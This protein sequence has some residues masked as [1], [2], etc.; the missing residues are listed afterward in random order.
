MKKF[1]HIAVVKSAPLLGCCLVF[2]A[3]AL[4][5]TG[6]ESG[7]DRPMGP[8]G[9]N[10]R[11]T[12]GQNYVRI[13]SL[14]TNT[15][16]YRAG[17]RV[18]DFIHGAFG[19]EFGVTPSGDSVWNGTGFQG[20]VQDFGLS[21]ERAEEGSGLLPLKVLRA[22][23]GDLT[24][25]V[26]LPGTNALGPAYP[27]NSVKYNEWYEIACSNLHRKLINGNGNIGYYTPYAGLALMGHPGALQTNGPTPYRLALD[28]IRDRVV[29]ALSNCVYAPVEGALLDGTP[30]PNAQGGMSNWELGPRTMFLAEYLALTADTNVLPTLQ[31]AAEVC[32]NCIQWWNVSAGQTTNSIWNAGHTGHGGVTGDYASG[33]LGMNITGLQMISGMALAARAGVDMNARPRDG[34]YFGFSNCPPGAVKAGLENYDHT[35]HEKLLMHWDNC[36]FRSGNYWGSDEMWIGYCAGYG[37]AEDSGGRTPATLFSIAAYYPD[38]GVLDAS[39]LERIRRLKNWVARHYWIQNNTHVCLQPGPLLQQMATAYL[40]PRQQRYYMDNWRFY[41]NFTRLSPT[42][43]PY[44]PGRGSSDAGCYLS[45][46]EGTLLNFAMALTVAR[47]GLPNVPGFDT[48]Q[49]LAHCKSP[50]LTWPDESAKYVKVTNAVTPFVVD[51]CDGLGV[52][53]APGSYTA[54]WALVSGPGAVSFSDTNT[55]STTVTFPYNGRYTLRLTATRGSYT[56]VEPINIDVMQTALPPGWLAGRANYEVFTGLTGTFISNLTAAAKFPG[57]PDQFRTVTKLEGTYSGDNYGARLRGCLLA[58]ATGSY[59][60]YIAANES[61]EFWF[62]ST[63]ATTNGLALACVVTNKTAQYQW[64][65]SPGQRSVEFAL[66]MGVPYYFEALHK[67][68]TGSDDVAVAWTGPG[69]SGTNVVGSSALV[70][71][72]D[73]PVIV[74]QPA[75]ATAGLGDTAT[76]SVTVAASPAVYQWRFNGTPY[77]T[78]SADATLTLDN[79]GGGHAGGYDVVCTTP[80]GVVTSA[81][82]Q[83]TVTNATGIVPGGLWREVYFSITGGTVADLTNS[84]KFPRLSDASSVLDSAEAPPDDGDSYGQRWTGWLKPAETAAYRFYL[85]CDDSAELWLSSDQFSGHKVRLIAASGVAARAWPGVTPSAYVALEA[86]RRYYLEVLHKESSGTDHLALTW[87]KLGDPAPLAGAAPIDSAFLEYKEGG[88]YEDTPPAPPLPVL[89]QFGAVAAQAKTWEVLAN[90]LD[91]DNATLGLVFVTAPAHGGA[92]VSGLRTVEYTSAFGFSGG[93]EFSYVV[94]N[95]AGLSAT[96]LVRVAV[97]GAYESWAATHGAVAYWPL[98]ETN[99][100]TASDYFGGH[101]GAI[102]GNVQLGQPGPRPPVFGGMDDANLAPVFDGSAGTRLD[103]PYAPALNPAVFTAELWVNCT[104]GS[105]TVRSPLG[106]RDTS[107]QNNGYYFYALDAAAGRRWSFRTGNGTNWSALD[108]PVVVENEW[109]HLAG[110]YDGTNQQFFVNGALAGSVA[111]NYAVNTARLLRIGGGHNETVPGT[112]FFLGSID[113]VALYNRAFTAA[114]VQEHYRLGAPPAPALALVSPATPRVNVPSGV[115]LVLET[116]ASAPVN[117]SNLVLAWSAVSG[118]GPVTF[119]PAAATNTTAVFSSTGTYVLRLTATDAPM[120]TTLDLTV[121]YGF[122]PN[123]WSAVAVGSVPAASGYAMSNSATFVVA[124]GGLGI[125]SAATADHFEFINQPASGDVEITARVLSVQNVA[126]SDSRAGVMIRES[127]NSNARHAFAGLNSLGSGRWIWRATAGAASANAQYTAAQPYWVRLRRAGNVFTAFAAPNS[128][129]APGT[130]TQLGT[131]TITMNSAVLIGL[132]AGSGSAT[133]TNR[134]V[135]DFVSLTPAPDN[136]GPLVSAGPNLL[137]TNATLTLRGTATDDGVPN[138]PA[139]LTRAWSQISGPAAV[140]FVN[141]ALTNTGATFPLAGDYVLRLVADDGAVK[142]FDEMVVTANAALTTP[143]VTL[144]APPHGEN[145]IAPAEISLA[146]S[147]TAN[148]N[149]IAKVQFFNGPTLLAED[150][151]APYEAAWSGVSAGLYPLVARVVANGH[152]VADSAPVTVTVTSQP[153]VVALTAPASGATFV[154]PAIIP[155]AA[156]VTANG[157]PITRVQFFNGPTLLGEDVSAP[158]TFTWPGA[159]AGSY[160]LTAR[161]LFAGGSVDSEPVGVTV[162]FAPPTV[163]LLNPAAARV[164]IPNG[165]GL[166]LAAAAATTWHPDNLLTGWSQVSGPGTVTFGDP[167]ATNTTARFSAPGAYVLRFTA[168]DLSLVTSTDLTVNAGFVPEPW[169]GTEIVTMPE[170]AGFTN[171][172]GVFTV[173]AAGIGIPSAGT[174]D[175]FYF[176]QQ[177]GAGSLDIRA[178]VVS[179]EALNGSSSRAGVM[180]REAATPNAREAFVGVPGGNNGTRWIWRNTPGGASASASGP[181]LGSAQPVWVRLVRSNSVFTAYFATN[182]NNAPDLWVQIGSPQTLAISNS[183]L[184]GLAG[185]SGLF[186]T[187][188][189]VVMDNVSITPG[190]DNVG[191]LVSA[192]NNYRNTNA[193]FTLQGATGD[194]G[195]PAPPALLTTA[196]SQLNGPATAAFVNAALTNTTVNFPVPGDYLLRLTAG[197]GQVQTFTDVLISTNSALAPPTVALTTPAEGSIFIAPGLIPLAASVAGNGNVVT[198]VQFL[199]GSLLL[200]ADPDA[201]YEF[202]WTGVPPGEYALVAR[203]QGDDGGTADSAPV[204]VLVPPAGVIAWWKFDETSGTNAADASGFNHPGSVSGATWTA[205]RVNNSLSFDGND[206]VTVPA[207]AGAGLSNEITVALW[208]YGNEAALP[209]QTVAFYAADAAGNKVLN[210]HLPWSDG[211]IYWDAGNSG[212]SSSDRLEQAASADEYEGRWSHWVFTKNAVTGEMKIYLN[213]AVWRSGSTARTRWLA[214]IASMTIGSTYRGQLDDFRIYN[215]ALSG[216]QVLALFDS[217]NRAPFATADAAFVVKNTTVTL[218]VLA[219]DTDPDADPLT[220]QSVTAAA[221]GTTTPAGTN[222]TYAPALDYLGPDAFNYVISDGK[223]HSVTGAVNITVTPPPPAITLVRPG[224]SSVNIPN[225]VG[226]VLDVAVTTTYTPLNLVF[227]WTRVSGPGPVT[228]TGA[229]STNATVLFSAPGTYA[230]GF[231]ATD[232]P[233]QSSISLIVNVGGVPNPWASAG[234]GTTPATVGYTQSV[235]GVFT[236]I[237]GGAGIQSAGTDD[238]FHFIHQAARGDLEIR[239]RVV[240]V[241]DVAA[242]SS[243]AGVMIREAATRNAREAFMGVTAAN[244]GRWIWRASPGATS[245]NV[246]ATAAQPYWVRLV[247]SNNVFTAYTAPNVGNAPGAWTAQGSQTIAMSNDVRLGLAATSG[248]ATVTNAVVIDNVAITPAQYN[249]NLAPFVH[250]GADAAITAPNLA[251]AGVA[252]DDGAF[253]TAWT[254]LS[255][256][257]TATFVNAAL[258]NTTATFPGTGAYALRLTASDAQARTFDDLLIT[259]A[260]PE[261]PRIM[262]FLPAATPGAFRFTLGDTATTNYTVLASADLVNWT[263]LPGVLHYAGG[264]FTITDPAAATNAHR[265]YRLRWP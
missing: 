131:Q 73:W 263:E 59:R 88:L 15:A 23:V 221:H 199:A 237:G 224:V 226:L 125:P 70:V 179:V 215:L 164:N 210:I 161:A 16:G 146:A 4:T 107:P 119:G 162:D 241:Q 47:G 222:V 242:S 67:E 48:N 32:A 233:L 238:D 259:R 102:I 253:T 99:G 41:Y 108:G 261:P 174:F 127:T 244:G 247:R 12:G 14:A 18:N 34:H 257:D 219:N 80:M 211:T 239:A 165:V 35:L 227:A 126:G 95:A 63:G 33:S 114:E 172:G 124:G 8:I 65:L 196:W 228:F 115:G 84:T 168:T 85:A 157:N 141:A 50:F 225:A 96:G 173:T 231:T 51:I 104:G 192:G 154:A 229:N 182:V 190:Q 142:T 87:Q 265:F 218:N 31:R 262:A 223:G 71:P 178:R 171:N 101:H 117:S 45:N 155:L 180:I 52:P 246:A 91:A 212:T 256:P 103:V 187:N 232:T 79:I 183:F 90:D 89:D 13:S 78:A 86:G 43:T 60:F 49:I 203:A 22:G 235:A 36:A 144:I 20:A 118:P 44:F 83:L 81:V 175:D 129:S 216:A 159:T 185:T 166:V 143:V 66:T 150:T 198:N 245:G 197:D 37:T 106:S 3:A 74:R 69:L 10:C 189:A 116:T 19:E 17:L 62:N 186:D 134:A 200:G 39:R 53:L 64:D 123:V 98:N 56:N 145:F 158:Y 230:L 111:T 93:D 181:A 9:G 250:A 54:D 26:P 133:A 28:K 105:D 136:V 94:T 132:A 137:R 169:T 209:A 260:L 147:V 151:T 214:P 188:G 153:P 72:P 68:G 58:P 122:V 5:S 25:V 82:A 149:A 201:P 2:L 42:A 207:A 152:S 24:I 193:S 252:S 249:L 21:I 97:V 138:P 191:P 156:D 202:T 213:G 217:Y 6:A 55:A 38:L 194:D 30:N 170:G 206:V 234:V 177:P 254:Q 135:F 61:A 248:S 29:P 240:S 236:I 112:Y 176:V 255:G 113:E 109:T 208:A 251:L 110:L 120:T 46:E 184:L 92:V 100:T 40:S 139:S 167:A 130:W 57:L 75:D 77:G 140:T 11:L 1:F 243:R 76:F 128:G 205:G 160:A 258:T 195:L 264:V 7:Y 148:G 27:L 204:N 220:L 163:A 121:N